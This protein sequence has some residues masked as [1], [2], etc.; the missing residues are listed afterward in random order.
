MNE[1][2]KLD[3]SEPTIAKISMEDRDAPN[4]FSQAL[5]SGLTETFQFLRP[6]TK[7]IVILSKVSINS[8]H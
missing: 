6:E 4:T 7:V 8:K 1:V 2:V 5:I 3:Y